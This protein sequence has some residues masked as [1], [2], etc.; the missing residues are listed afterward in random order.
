[1]IPT[2]R[3]T[4]TISNTVSP[5]GNDSLLSLGSLRFCALLVAA[6]L[7]L[8]YLLIGF[9]TDQLVLAGLFSVLYF[10]SHV[11]R[12]FIM[13]FS[14]FILYW[15][16]F[17]YM[18]AFPNYRYNTVHIESLYNAEKALFG[19]MDAGRRVTPNEFF[20]QH[21]HAV[22]DLFAG[23][24]YLCWVPV[25]LIF[26]AVL[27]F[28]HRSYYF[29]FAFSFLLVNLIGFIGYYL[30]P[31]APPWYVA[32]RGF[33]FIANTPGNTAALA[34][35]DALTG[36]P[37]FAGLYSKS[38][39]VFAAMPSLHAAYMLVVL[40]YGIRMKLGW[41][42]G[43]FALILVGIWFTAVYSSHHYILDV[44]G[45]IACTVL[46]LLLFQRF[47]RSAK[48]KAWLLRLSATRDGHEGNGVVRD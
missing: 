21:H 6:Y 26:A 43:L 8:S 41:I 39:N 35:F 42:N 4:R 48:G 32:E 5:R 9:K 36:I 28:R 29:Q 44:L 46:A 1:M 16:I 33:D 14:V 31:A 25:P 37:V 19:F 12:R 24:F 27:Y 40:Y 38:S 18:K 2:A 30:Y 15:I 17:D 3:N 20:A 11:T 10:A 47:A 7:S 45:G 23:F 22:T 34:R 13:A